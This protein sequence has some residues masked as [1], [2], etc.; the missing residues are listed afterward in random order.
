MNVKK[1]VLILTKTKK[2]NKISRH[3][4]VNV[5]SFTFF[6]PL[7]LAMF[8]MK[9]EPSTFWS[10]YID[11]HLNFIDWVWGGYNNQNKEDE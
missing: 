8:L 1:M 5:V 7:F 10:R 9:K 2:M 4:I 6:L 11:L 3:L